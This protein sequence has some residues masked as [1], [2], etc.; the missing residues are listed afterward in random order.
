MKIMVRISSTALLGLLTFGCSSGWCSSEPSARH[1]RLS[2]GGERIA[3]QGGGYWTCTFDDEFD[4]HRLDTNQWTPQQT[5]NSAYT[6]GTP[7]AAACYENSRSNVSV[8]GGYLN[9]TARE[10]PAPFTCSYPG[11]SFTTQYTSGMVTTVYGV[12]Q[13]YGRFEVRAKLPDTA[14]EGLQE[15]LWLWPVNDTYY[16][17]YPA[18]G[19]IDFAEF[20]SEYATL[21]VPYIHYNYDPSTVNPATNT[22]IVTA[23]NCSIDYTKFNVYTVVWE[24]GTI[25]LMYNGNTCLVDNYVPDNGLTSPEPFDQP[26]FVS[27]TQALGGVGT[28]PFTPGTTPLP[29]TLQI[30][31][32]RVWK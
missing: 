6:T 12:H 4:G 29:A 31:Y 16:G 20:Y 10:E 7:T 5:S 14:V 1:T 25:T 9:L 8:F 28:N 19:E 2:C 21:D 30:D 11:G 13:T 17:A 18:S 32:V 15:T 23:Y 24:P 27:L 22:N 26:F 3:K